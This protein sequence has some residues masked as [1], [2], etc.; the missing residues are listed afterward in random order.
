MLKIQWGK[1][2]SLHNLWHNLH[3]FLD[4]LEL[5]VENYY[6]SLKKTVLQIWSQKSTR[7]TSFVP[8]IVQSFWF[9]FFFSFLTFLEIIFVD[10]YTSFWKQFC[11]KF[12]FCLIFQAQGCLETCVNVNGVT[13]CVTTK[14]YPIEVWI[15]E[16]I[17]F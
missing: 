15:L 17:I 2:W 12:N 5:K 10:K 8:R 3:M 9:F 16:I 13:K 1:F 4:I 7:I 14:F 6:I 11:L